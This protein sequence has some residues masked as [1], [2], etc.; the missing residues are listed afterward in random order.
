MPA[1]VLAGVV[2]LGALLLEGPKIDRARNPAKVT[3]T[4]GVVA[5]L[6]PADEAAY[7]QAKAQVKLLEDTYRQ[8]ESTIAPEVKADFNRS[9]QSLDKSIQEAGLSVNHEGDSGMAREYL[10]VAYLQKAEV[11]SS[12]L[13]YT[14]R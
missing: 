6:S 11:L 1:A 4:E 7:R 3:S 13:Q 5:A 12:A 9:L 10:E 14:G 2:F 8:Q